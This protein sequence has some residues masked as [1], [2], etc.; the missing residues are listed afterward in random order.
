M[1]PRAVVSMRPDKVEPT[2]LDRAK[3]LEAEAKHAQMELAKSAIAALELARAE[4]DATVSLTLIPVGIRQELERTAE[5]IGA[6]L[7]TIKAIA[8]REVRP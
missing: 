3:R 5:A 4:C 2:P 1:T 7:D 6:R 8:G